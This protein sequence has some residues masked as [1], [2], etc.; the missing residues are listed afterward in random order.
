MHRHHSAIHRVGCLRNIADVRRFH[1]AA[2]AVAG[3][4]SR[5][6]LL[7]QR[8]R[9]QTVRLPVG[10]ARRLLSKPLPHTQPRA[11]HAGPCGQRTHRL[12]PLPS[13]EHEPDGYQHCHAFLLLLAGIA[14]R[15]AGLR[16]L[17]PDLR[18]AVGTDGPVVISDEAQPSV[19]GM[20]RH[21]GPVEG[22]RTGMGRRSA[23]FCL[24]FLP[25]RPPH[26][27]APRRHRTGRGHSLLRR[28]LH[29]L[30]LRHAGH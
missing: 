16:R 5:R 24:R 14:G 26:G 2:V 9:A 15:H 19:G 10:T 7:L 6:G 22:E 8:C 3:A 25:D 4:D 21:G 11:H 23:H 18:A 17:Q 29:H 30:P 13:V 28:L 20:C 27:T 1:V 12:R